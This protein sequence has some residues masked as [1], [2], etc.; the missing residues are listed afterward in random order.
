MPEAIV[1]D[2]NL[3]PDPSTIVA[4]PDPAIADPDPKPEPDA[5]AALDIPDDAVIEVMV[6]GV[7]TRMTGKE[8]KGGWQRQA[9]YTRK[10]QS[11]SAKGKEIQNLWDEITKQK[12]EL[13]AK[14]LALDKVLGRAPKTDTP[15]IADDEMLTHGQLKQLLSEQFGALEQR[16]TQGASV[17]SKEESEARTTQ[18]WEDLIETTKEKLVEEFPNLEDIPHLTTVLK[19]EAGNT[20]PTTEKEMLQAII[21]AGKNTSERIEKRFVERQKEVAVKKATLVKNGPVPPGGSPQLTT[22]KTYMK[23][24]SVDWAELEKDVT[25]VLQSEE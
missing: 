4:D 21:D 17:R 7:A 23:G 1:N 11:V 22:Q 12:V 10:T 15:V 13:D 19:R 6:D 25:A 8:A 20:N 24:R 14:D 16:M 18:R 5:K 9:D 2:P 3:E